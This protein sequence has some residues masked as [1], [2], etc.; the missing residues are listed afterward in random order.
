[1]NVE[2]EFTCNKF[3]DD[4]K[5]AGKQGHHPQGPWQV[6][7]VDLYGLQEVLRGHVLSPSPASGEPK[8]QVGLRKYRDQPWGEKLTSVGLQEEIQ[9]DPAMCICH[10]KCQI[11]PGQHQKQHDLQD[12]GSD[13]TLLLCSCNTPPGVLS[14]ALGP[15]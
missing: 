13:S 14:L 15:Q 3:A 6:W 4:S 5:H 7:E 1:M 10:P 11:H 2:I 8:I 12:K 9:H